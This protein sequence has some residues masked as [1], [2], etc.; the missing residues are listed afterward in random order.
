M[1]EIVFKLKDQ[2][3]E[4][5]NFDPVQQ[6]ELIYEDIS[7]NASLKAEDGAQGIKEILKSCS[8]KF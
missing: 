6:L 2:E 4:E 3:E 7:V 8:G 5:I 1:T